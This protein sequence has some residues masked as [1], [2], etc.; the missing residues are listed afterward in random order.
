[1]DLG[2]QRAGLFARDAADLDGGQAP[3]LRQRELVE[4][5]A[6][7]RPAIRRL[8]KLGAVGQRQKGAAPGLRRR[9]EARVAARAGTAAS[10]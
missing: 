1:M 10:S 3:V 8:V 6:V 4:E 5:D 7:V 9:S 2:L